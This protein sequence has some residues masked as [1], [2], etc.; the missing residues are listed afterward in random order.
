MKIEK[1]RPIPK[2]IKAQIKR[3][4]DKAYKP[5]EGKAR[6]Y[7]YLTKNDGELVKVTVAA[8]TYRKKWYCKQVAVHGVHSD[9]CF[10]LDLAFYCVGGYVVDWYAEGIQKRPKLW[11]YE[12]CWGEGY[13]VD[14]DPY[15]PV[16]N[17]E[18]ALKF[19]EY[20]YSAADEYKYAGILK[21]LRIY[22]Q[23]PQA[24]L[25]VKFGLSAYATSKQILRKTAKDRQFRKWLI[26]HRNELSE[27]KYNV[28]TILNAFKSG[29]PVAK[30]QKYENNRKQLNQPS[31]FTNIKALF[32][33][34]A[35]KELLLNYLY[36]HDANLSS[37]SD[38]LHACNFLGVDMNVEKNRLP[39]DFQ[40]WHDIRIDEY[41]TAKAIIDEEKRKELYAEFAAIAEKYQTL[42][43]QLQDAY[44][45]K[46]ARTP[47]DLIKEGDYLHHCVG[48]MNYDRRMI[49]EE[50]LIFFLRNIA[51]PDTPF[52]TIEYSPTSKRILQCYGDSDIP[53]AADVLDFVNNKWLPYANRKLEQI[54]A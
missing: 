46:I 54:A 22:E 42:Q 26:Q 30:L 33:D 44:I 32:S 38:Y 9:K 2:Y 51:E 43:R 6:F 36:K 48:R 45:V 10:V 52:V 17:K 40:R 1:I 37:Y 4:D 34:D 12:N 16:V 14:F 29:K 11:D 35:E 31:G 27:G 47:A 8:K 50:S 5:Q 39:R 49:R 15:A 25:L 24:E 19:P 3:L 18:Y 41:S 7:A 28:R 23:F 13:D 20:K 21:Y 53:P